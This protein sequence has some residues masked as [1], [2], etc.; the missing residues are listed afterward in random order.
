M[1]AELV[2]VREWDIII[3]LWRKK[4]LISKWNDVDITVT[5]NYLLTPVILHWNTVNITMNTVNITVN[6]INITIEY[7]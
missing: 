1:V 6:Q 3:L 7:C 2:E 4:V 5:K